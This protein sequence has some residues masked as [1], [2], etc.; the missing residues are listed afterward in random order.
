M[1]FPLKT[2]DMV[3]ACEEAL[4]LAHS[5]E[6]RRLRYYMALLL[7]DMAGLALGFLLAGYGYTGLLFEDR[8]MMEL[9][10]LLPVFL[11]I[12]LYNRAYSMAALGSRRDSVVLML[13]AL[14]I[15][16]AL[17]N[18]IAFYAKS[19]AQF[20]RATFTLGLLM[21]AAIM[22]LIR[23]RMVNWI[24]RRTGS[25]LENLLVIEDQGHQLRLPG[26]I[27]ISAQDHGLAP[28]TDDPYILNRLGN[29]LRN[30]DRVIVSCPRDRRSDWAVLLKC[31]GVR[32][33]VLSDTVRDMGALGVRHYPDQDVA[34]L[35]IATGPLGLR[36]RAVKRG[37][38]IAFSLLIILLAAPLFVAVALLIKLEDGGPVFFSQR[39]LGRSNRFF[40]IYKFRSM[41]VAEA[42]ADGVRSTS[43][44]DDRVTRMGRPLR[45]TSIDE[46]PQLLNVLKGEMSIVGPRPHALAS[47]AGAKL[48]WEVD[49]EYWRRHCLKPGLT[50]L[51]QVRGFR[52]ATER[53]QD[54]SRRL[55]ADLEYLHDWS[56]WRDLAIMI[57]TLK[58]LIHERAY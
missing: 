28:R 55:Q 17:L 52:G 13:A 33:E 26:A 2:S 12:G 22:G 15:A 14:V 41:K 23:V 30:M 5:F 45:A 9:Q 4:P 57:R 37:F 16:S 24:D 31:M 48:F 21:G 49:P 39:R 20:S 44:E 38:D 8:A 50:G 11:T 10:L 36:S 46:L 34:T 58:V 47:Q 42:D 1:N 7:G 29:C 53:E 19:N 27:T 56:L 35:T 43:R 40:T 6:R 32:G 25:R 54:L 18:F 51:A 3:V